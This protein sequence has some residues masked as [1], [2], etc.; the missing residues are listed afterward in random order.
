MRELKLSRP[1]QLW[2]AGG[3][4]DGKEVGDLWGIH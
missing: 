3:R 4:Q 1:R 2:P